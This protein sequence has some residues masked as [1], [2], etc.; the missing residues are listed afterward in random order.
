MESEQDILLDVKT[1]DCD[2]QSEE[3]GFGVI[4]NAFIAA[5]NAFH[6]PP[7]TFFKGRSLVKLAKKHPARVAADWAK[8]GV[9][10]SDYLT[11]LTRVSD[12]IKGFWFGSTES[13]QLSGM[14][15]IWLHR[16][17][18][19][20]SGA[21]DCAEAQ[22]TSVPL[23]L[24]H[25]GGMPVPGPSRCCHSDLVH[26]DQECGSQSTNLGAL[27]FADCVAAAQ[28]D[29]QCHGYIMYS[30]T[31]WSA[32][33]CRCCAS[34]GQDGGGANALWAVYSY[35]PN[36]TPAGEAYGVEGRM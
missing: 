22:R 31:Y 1:S 2:T 29:P 25:A 4:S 17:R 27:K 23:L 10:S 32:W 6:I 34:G 7:Y 9:I 12:V 26:A 3:C 14:Q 11:K 35:P 5:V 8:E 30:E 28:L 19:L 36:L 20:R 13:V 18:M 16:G 24:L 33:G 15:R 21:R